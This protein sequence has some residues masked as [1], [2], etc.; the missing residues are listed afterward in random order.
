MILKR[1]KANSIA[2][3]SSINYDAEVNI[4]INDKSSF[5]KLAT[6]SDSIN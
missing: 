3:M 4:S 2:V 5:T 6:K 1:E